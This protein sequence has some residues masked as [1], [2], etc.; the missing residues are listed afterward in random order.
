MSSQIAIPKQLQDGI[1]SFQRFFFLESVFH[2]TSLFEKNIFP[3]PS[4][5][6]KNSFSCHL[7]F[8]NKENLPIVYFNDLKKINEFQN[9]QI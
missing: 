8:E 9:I 4:K 1:L 7:L 6:F 2:M 5:N 3:T